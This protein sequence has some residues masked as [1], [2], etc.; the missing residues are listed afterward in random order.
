MYNVNISVQK[1]LINALVNNTNVK[2]IKKWNYIHALP[3][4]RQD[5]RK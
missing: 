5:Y 4:F 2:L 3:V 1:I